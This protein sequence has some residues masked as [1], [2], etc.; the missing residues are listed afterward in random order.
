MSINVTK[1]ACSELADVMSRELDVYLTNTQADVD[2]AIEETAKETVEELNR[3]SPVRK[4]KGGGKY[5]K[6]WDYKKDGT[7]RG[8]YRNSTVVYAEGKQ[9]RLT[10]LLEFGHAK[11]NGG[12]VEA[13]PHIR[14]AEE[15]AA[16]R[17]YTK[18]LRKL[19]Y[20]DW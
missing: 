6:S 19:R 15:N 12:R 4:G 11:V 14:Q 16:T 10:H 13:R 18:L 2:A 20:T 8:M 1:I 9:Y 3:T 17:L 5:A 7:I